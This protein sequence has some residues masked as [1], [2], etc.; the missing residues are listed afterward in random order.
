M[1]STLHS[2]VCGLLP[3][4]CTIRQHIILNEMNLYTVVYSMGYEYQRYEILV[5]K[6]L[7]IGL[8][9]HLVLLYE[10]LNPWFVIW[11]LTTNLPTDPE[12]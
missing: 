9:T 12:N 6:L 4:I 3:L 11:L 2:T 7:C 8:Y 1:N 5:L 10:S